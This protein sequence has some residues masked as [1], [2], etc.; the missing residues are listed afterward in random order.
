MRDVFAAEDVAPECIF[1]TDP[2]K[3]LQWACG[4]FGSIEQKRVFTFQVGIHHLKER[5]EGQEEVFQFQ[6]E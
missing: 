2:E 5:K 3:A 1:L 4:T 6:P